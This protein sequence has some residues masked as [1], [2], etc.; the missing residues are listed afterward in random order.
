MRR[1]GKILNEQGIVKNPIVVVNRSGRRVD[2]RH[3]L[4][5][6]PLRLREPTSSPSPTAFSTPIAQG[7]PSCLRPHDAARHLRADAAASSSRSR[8]T[9]R[10]S[11]AELMKIAKEAPQR[12]D[13]GRQLRPRPTT[14]WPASCEKATGAQ[15]TYIP[16]DGGGAALATFLGGNTDMITLPIDE[17]LPLVQAGKAQGARHPQ[18]DAHDRCRAEGHPDRQ[19]TGHRRG[20]GPDLRHAGAAEARPGRGRMVGRSW[21]RTGSAPGMEEDARQQFLRRRIS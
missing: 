10:T 4:R 3:E 9:R 8:T 17:A 20:V 6:R 2:R 5:A 18:R 12:Q 19:G 15:L 11:C 1:M 14:K 13:V 7:Q 21:S 16:H